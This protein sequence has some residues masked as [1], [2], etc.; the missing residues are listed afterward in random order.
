MNL[1]LAQRAVVMVVKNRML[2]WA[3]EFG[4]VQFKLWPFEFG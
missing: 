1:Y 4:K 2:K 3:F